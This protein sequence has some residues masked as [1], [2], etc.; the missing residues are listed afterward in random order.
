VASYFLGYVAGL[1]AKDRSHDTVSWQLTDPWNPRT[2][3]PAPVR[4]R[5]WPC[6][7]ESWSG[8]VPPPCTATG[9]F[10]RVYST[11]GHFGAT[12]VVKL[13]A[14]Q[15]DVPL[16][17]P[18]DRPELASQ[19]GYAYLEAWTGTGGSRASYE[20]GLVYHED[21][22]NFSLYSRGSGEA[23]SYYWTNGIFFKAGDRVRL[24]L[25]GYPS[26]HT[27]GTE[28]P[29]PAAC[30][31]GKLCLIGLAQDLTSHR[32]SVEGF[33]GFGWRGDKA[34]LARMTTI[35][36]TMRP[37]HAGNVF[38]DGAIFG[39][40]TW[41][42]AKLAGIS[43]KGIT[44]SAWSGHAQSWPNDRTRVI[45]TNPSGRSGLTGEMDALYLHP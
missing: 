42:E 4:Y 35:A 32:T 26:G 3:N 37:P 20:F 36:Q 5:H 43:A 13:P 31:G 9:A 33:K 8:D 16:T 41:S 30:T 1:Y 21:S 11:R 25:Y 22:N 28:W 44:P 23:G 38:D 29:A 7:D 34:I 18:G 39:L 19:A 27:G 12:A 40:I 2:G 24:A 17:M 14:Q 6:A 15:S 45:V 10:R